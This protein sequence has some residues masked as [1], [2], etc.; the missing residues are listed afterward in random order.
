MN[1]SNKVIEAFIGLGGNLGDVHAT[2]ESAVNEIAKHP[3]IFEIS[4]SRFYLT[5]PVSSIPQPDYV[6][7]VCSI[8]TTLDLRSLH[9]F[10]QTIEKK[11]GKIEKR[12]DEPRPIDLDIL[13]FG[14]QT[15]N[16]D[17]LTVPHPEWRNRLFVLTPLMDLIDKI[18]VPHGTSPDEFETIDLVKF[19]ETFANPHSETLTRIYVRT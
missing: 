5:S 19:M 17:D 2:L 7:A 12:K 6:N 16:D 14:R 18:V 10:L 15:C 3:E 9:K 1:S 4:L 11:F 8:E 13:F